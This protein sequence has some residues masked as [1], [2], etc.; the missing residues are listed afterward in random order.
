MNVQKRN[1][2]EKE[3]SKISNDSSRLEEKK[4]VHESL[5][6]KLIDEPEILLK[7]KE[8]NEMEIFQ[9]SVAN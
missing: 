1:K 3:L 4:G 9:S 7:V 5:E 8:S 2:K 6:S